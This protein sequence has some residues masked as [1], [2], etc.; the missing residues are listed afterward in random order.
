MRNESKL[1]D[2]KIELSH[3]KWFKSNKLMINEMKYT[4]QGVD[5][6]IE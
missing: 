4:P 2:E 6:A 1:L 5:N 3:K